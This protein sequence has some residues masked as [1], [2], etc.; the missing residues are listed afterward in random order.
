MPHIVLNGCTIHYEERGRGV[1]VVLT[2]GGRWG[3]HVHRV[4]AAALASEFR[5]VTWD[6]RNCD[7]ASDIVI[8][9]DRSEAEIWADDLAALIAAL[10]L[11]PCYVGEYAGCR[12][13]PILCVR[14]PRLVKGLMLAWPSG[15]DVPAARLP[16]NFYQ[17]YTRAALRRG[18][19]GVVE[20]SHFAASI[21][22]NSGNRDRLLAMDPIEF[23]RQMGFWEAFFATS[24][25]LPVA[26]C[27]L[28]EAEW[29][30]IEV[31]ASVTG[32]VDPTHPTAAAER[33]KR[34]LPRAHYHA[35]VVEAA[36]WE[37]IF[38][39]NPYPVTADFQGE[40]IAPVWRQFLHSIEGRI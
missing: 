10:G 25:D 30:S 14:H 13:A 23:V 3:G 29:A 27:R 15:G 32:G 9:G 1:P 22:L 17:A 20:T 35:P 38:E 2:P 36:E 34:L 31:P 40:R 21:G 26:G 4:I 37:R 24:A 5:V 12:T 11:A 18:M 6:R 39:H 28:G 33:L 19:A 8:A 7:G 16:R